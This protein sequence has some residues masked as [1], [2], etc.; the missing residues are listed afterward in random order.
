[1]LDADLMP[2]ILSH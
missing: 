2:G 1:M